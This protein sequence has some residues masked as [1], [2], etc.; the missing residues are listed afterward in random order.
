MKNYAELLDLALTAAKNLIESVDTNTDSDLYAR[1]AAAAKIGEC[2]GKEIEFTRRQIHP[3]GATYEYLRKH[4]VRV[5]QAP[6]PATGSTGTV[7]IEGTPASTQAAGSEFTDADGLR[8]QTTAIA[9]IPAGGSV[10]VAAESIDTGG[11]VNW[12]DETAFTLTSPAAGIDAECEAASDFAGGIGEETQPEFLERHLN[13]LQKTAIGDNAPAFEE[14]GGEVEGV[15]TATAFEL[16]RGLGTC[17]LC[18]TAEYGAHVGAATLTAVQTAIDENRTVCAADCEATDFDAL[19]TDLTFQV[20]FDEGYE[21][22]DIGA[23]KTVQAGST[24]SEVLVD[25]VADLDAGDYVVVN[26]QC[27]V[28]ESIDAVA[29]SFTVTEPF[30]SAPNAADVVYPGSPSWTEVYDAAT[31]YVDGLAPGEDLVLKKLD[32][33][34]ANVDSVVNFTTVAP[35]ADVSPTVDSVTIERV[36]CGDVTI[37]EMP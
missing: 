4:G 23:N 36:T 3:Q 13:R 35:A 10:T 1:L 18:P 11:D 2:M 14:W 20:Q 15:D 8:G 31:G 16:R 30:T 27:R 32:R 37:E 29:V 26:E 19:A 24:V 25:S 5:N 22:S 17:D 34:V 33:A 6:N 28:I 7:T 9:T 12:P 21:F